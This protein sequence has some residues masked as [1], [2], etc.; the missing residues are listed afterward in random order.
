MPDPITFQHYEVLARN[1]GAPWELG[2]GAMGVTYKALDTNLR[3]PVALKVIHPRQLD[4]EIVAQRFVR[5]ARAAARLRHPHIAAVYHLGQQGEN[6]FYAMEFVAGDTAEALVK[7]DGPLPEPMVLTL[8]IQTARALN[9]AA[10]LGLVH[11]DIKPSN[12]ML[13]R[14]SDE[15]QVKLIDFGL[16]RTFAG[17]EQDEDLAAVT[18]SGF[19]GTPYYASPEQLEQ[20]ELDIR[21]DIYSLG[22]TLWFL[23][24]AK[25]PFTGSVVSVLSQHL[26]KRPPFEQLDG[27]VSPPLR[28]LLE[29]M[30]EKDPAARPQTALELRRALEACEEALPG[31]TARHLPTPAPDAGQPL[32]CPIVAPE[33]SAATEAIEDRAEPGS[34]YAGAKFDPAITVA[35]MGVGQLCRACECGTGREFALL[36]LGPQRGFDEAALTALRRVVERARDFE[37]PQVWRVHAIGAE[38]DGL[39]AVL[40]WVG[41]YPWRDL[42]RRRRELTP[43]EAFPLIESAARGIDAILARGLDRPDV[44]LGG[45]WCTAPAPD[46]AP[47]GVKVSPLGI[48]RACSLDATWMGEGTLAHPSAAGLEA[49]LPGAVRALAEVAY[50]TLGGV[51]AAR[52][53]PPLPALPE[54]ANKVLRTALREPAEFSSAVAFVEQLTAGHA[55]PAP[56]PAQRSSPPAE[57]AAPRIAE[58][59][60][61]ASVDVA[62][63]AM[64]TEASIEN[65]PAAPPVPEVEPR[66]EAPA[67]EPQRRSPLGR[68]AL[69][70]CVTLLAG[71]AGWYYTHRQD[72]PSPPSAAANVLPSAVQPP[73]PAPIAATPSATPPIVARTTTP[74]P[75][76]PAP[77]TPSPT[78]LAAQH[79]KR[80]D[81]FREKEVWDRAASE[82][83]AAH[84]LQPHS[85]EAKARLEPLFREVRWHYTPRDRQPAKVSK[86]QVEALV[87][88]LKQAADELRVP[89]AMLLLG[90]H[91]ESDWPQAIQWYEKA[92]E[93]APK[94]STR[95]GQVLVKKDP[96]PESLQR[97]WQCF[98]T[99]AERGDLD[100]KVAMAECLWFGD[101]GGRKVP[102]LEREEQRAVRLLR[103]AIAEADARSGTRPFDEPLSADTFE[104]QPGRAKVFLAS[105]YLGLEEK[106][107]A[108]R[109]AWYREERERGKIDHGAILRKLLKEATADRIEAYGYLGQAMRSAIG[110]AKD[111]TEAVALWQEGIE[112]GDLGCMYFYAHF[113]GTND[114]GQVLKV[115]PPQARQYMIEAASKGDGRA[116]AFCKIA[117]LPYPSTPR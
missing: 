49:G 26:H 20:R 68:L 19:V 93:L 59:S 62:S 30:L 13:A 36:E 96:K 67:W 76:T 32:P 23:L 97:A 54:G 27:L 95:I 75:S 16:A 109:P 106:P 22:V 33:D 43:A 29:Q 47:S 44:T 15:W 50:E 61:A 80:A 17:D 101:V 82:L 87:P 63:V 65:A 112:L 104:V 6:W 9:A 8:A 64:Q 52:D 77:A 81:E 58:E 115:I 84:R 111:K 100:G 57:T 51:M 66:L 103:E 91:Y 56:L 94:A 2:R 18:H 42:L 88:A 79:L 70:A 14:E 83:L 35:E 55:E 28:R 39:R 72:E 102:G 116:I 1:D 89:A 108:E 117:K 53:F 60:A 38:G 3:V 4:S 110:G 21:S 71:A 7:R 25:V 74:P 105:L 41:G 90:Q 86:A 12:L 31:T 10:S 99:A 45:L 48:L 73:A 40:D 24:T 5:E 98:Q 114:A 107:E 37:H 113:L 34:S 78:D 46:A 85:P 69:A 92:A 11:R